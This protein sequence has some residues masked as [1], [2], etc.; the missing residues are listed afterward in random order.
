VV[1]DHGV[2]TAVY[3]AV[4]EHAA[5]ATV[6]LARSD[7]TLIDWQQSDHG[8]VGPPTRDGVAE[9]RD[10]YVFSFGG[11][12]YAVQGAGAPDGEPLILLYECD[13]LERW[14]ELDPL[15]DYSDAIARKVATASIWECPNLF[16]LG[17]RWVLI[18]SSWHR[19]GLVGSHYLIGDLEPS[20]NRLRFVAE[21]G[22]GVD[23]G[24]SFYAPQVLSTPDRALLW[25]WARDI[26]RSAEQ[27]PASGW[28]GALTFPRELSIRD[29]RLVSEPAAELDGLRG[30]SLPAD[31][32]I[33]GHRFELR[34]SAG[35]RLRL[36]GADGDQTVIEEPGAARVF[37]DGSMIE[38]FRADQT[39]ATVRAYPAVG[40][41]WQAEGDDLTINELGLP[42]QD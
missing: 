39:A 34:A 37:V 12:R 1:D 9:A 16:P 15:L 17:G 8:V 33:S 10:P 32:P 38:I 35:L 23:T 21:A 29:G 42:P 24:K 31:Q 5:D 7:R 11:H 30:R 28:A 4:R 40:N 13:D 27:V 19:G 3:S 26:G 20:G 18:I 36:S 25:G 41:R 2:P 6:A 22:G 14:S